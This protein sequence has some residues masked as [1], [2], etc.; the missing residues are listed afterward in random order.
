MGIKNC[1]RCTSHHMELHFRA[2]SI[3]MKHCT[4]WIFC[5]KLH[6]PILMKIDAT[7]SDTQP[8]S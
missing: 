1:P 5:P 6:E 3:P 4:H 8:L 2:L 7:G